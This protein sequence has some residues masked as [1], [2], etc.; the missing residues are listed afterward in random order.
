[1][2][3]KSCYNCIFEHDCEIQQDSRDFCK[4]WQ[5]GKQK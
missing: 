3:D 2:I 5:E 4:Y 1:M